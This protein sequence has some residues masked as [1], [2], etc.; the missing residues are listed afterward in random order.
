MKGKKTDEKH[1]RGLGQSFVFDR[2]VILP[3]IGG[4]R[5]DN[6]LELAEPVAREPF[7]P[8]YNGWPDAALFNDIPGG[9]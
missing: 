6:V 9:M 5:A 7:I 3:L 2:P 1:A 8:T 4:M